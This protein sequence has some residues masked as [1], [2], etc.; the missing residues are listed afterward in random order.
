M[1][2]GKLSNVAIVDI[3]NVSSVSDFAKI[4]G[5]DSI[6]YGLPLILRLS[7]SNDGDSW[8]PRVR[9][10]SG[11]GV[12]DWGDG[13]PT[14][15]VGVIVPSPHTYATAGTYDVTLTPDAGSRTFTIPVDIN[16]PNDSFDEQVTEVL[17]F[18]DCQ[19]GGFY[20][21]KALETIP[22]NGYLDLTN[23]WEEELFRECR[24]FVGPTSMSGYATIT[25]TGTVMETA[26]ANNLL[27]NSPG[28]ND[29]DTS[30]VTKLE[31]TFFGCLVFNQPLDNWDV[32]SVTSMFATFSFA[33]VF[34]QDISGWN[35]GSVTNTKKMFSF[36]SAFNQDISG[37]NVSN[38]TT[39]ESMFLRATSFNQNL[40]AW[41]FQNTCD[42]QHF[43]AES[44]MS[45]ANV[46]LCL[47][48]WDSVGQ[49]T[50]VDARYMFQ[51]TPSSNPPTPRTLS[52]STYPNAKTAYDNLISTYSWDFTGSFNW[53]A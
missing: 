9:M 45:D 42:I 3:D 32:S 1:E 25:P 46:A 36:A 17:N 53:I 43:F 28:L 19:I 38:V 31:F 8:I 7:I 5:V 44:G 21:W 12:I 13:S 52:E 48:G 2:I 35:V 51:A 39:M 30:S 23:F 14:E 47:E 27:F 26:F 20:F 34:N 11:T 24:S 49:G 18:G 50:N 41:R 10:F 40:G 16:D 29:L 37:W 4:S 22:L 6:Q 15:P 33:S